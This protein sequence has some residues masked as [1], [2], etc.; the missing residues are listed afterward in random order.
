MK[1]P[2]TA[3]ELIHWL[4]VGAGARWVLRAAT[5]TGVLALSLLIAWGQFHGP[6]TELTLLQAGTGHQL[7]RGQGFTTLVNYPQTSA[8]LAKRGTPFDVSQ[9]YPELHEAPLYSL[10][11]AGALCL[12]P[13]GLR[14]SLFGMP[15]V[16]P[17]GF[18]ADYFLLG[19]N[20]ALFWLAA[21]L[22]FILARRLFDARTGWLASVA[23]L[24]SVAAWQQTVLVNGMPLLMVLSL[25]A[26]WVLARI[27]GEPTAPIVLAPGWLALLG[28]V[29]GLLF[30]TEYS[31]GAFVLVALAHSVHRYEGRSRWMALALVTACFALVTTPWIVR[32]VMLTGNPVGLAAQNLALKA[33]DPTAEPASQRSMFT[34]TPPEV[35][36]NKLGNKVLTSLEENLKSRLWS[37]GAMWLTAFFAT[38]W[39]YGFRSR[40][41][42]RLRWTFTAA[43][44]VLL[45]SQA[46]F[47]S[48]ESER[49]V[50]YW[51]APLV[52]VFGAGFFF[53]LLGSNAWL[54]SWPRLCAAAL[55]VAQALP[56][57]RDALEPRKLHFSYPPYFPGLFLG[58]RYELERRDEKGIFGVM[59]DVP[60]G[61]AWYAGQRVWAQPVKM[62][63]FYA[64]SLE[65]PLAE[66]LLTPRTLDR[67]FF[68]ELAS[69]P[70]AP[71]A[72]QATAARFGDWGQVYGGLF[73][74]TLPPE[75][76]LGAPQRLAENLY[77]LLN[78]ALPPA[79]GK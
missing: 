38:G 71:G 3:Q 59:A 28:A 68:T 35:N 18:G 78:P 77:V 34:A 40:A 11:I 2:K 23:L 56:L 62:R 1:R 72:V 74:G 75:F 17:D 70:A 37:G 49:L 52:M 36:L 32:N 22:T 64:V 39:L 79:R 24:V 20:L 8:F 25:F 13:H 61:V 53:V 30:L 15:P 42:N 29:C 48:G 16:P 44:G 67:P 76:P 27:E 73:T 65:Q 4:E 41:A 63:D 33:G 54:G 10:V 58:M 9:P 60:A 31:A 55:L 69:R 51:L 66:L 21:W 47:N 46:V 45:V 26:F 14:E 43:L 19:L 7:A 12:L 6:T 57:V 50:S 5:V